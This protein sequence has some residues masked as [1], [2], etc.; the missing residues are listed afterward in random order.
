METCSSSRP[1]SSPL[2]ANIFFLISVWLGRKDIG[3]IIKKNIGIGLT[4][5][6]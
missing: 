4:L 6:S 1:L 3:R 2:T 5:A